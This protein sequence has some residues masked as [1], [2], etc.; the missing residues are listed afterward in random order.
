MTIVRYRIIF[1]IFSGILFVAS[2]AAIAGYG[3]HYGIDFTG[4]ALIEAG[5]LK[6]RPAIDTIRTAL[7]NAGFPEAR[8]QAAGERDVLVRIRTLDAAGHE[9][10]LSAIAGSP[11]PGTVLM[12]KRFDSIGPTIGAELR[13]KAYVAIALVLAL[14]LI[15]ISWAFR[16]VSRPISSWKYA[17]TAI[18]ALA[19]DVFLPAGMFAVLGHFYGVEADALFIT[20]LLTVLGFS[21]HDTIVVFDRIRENL[22]KTPGEKFD[23]IVGRSVTET[24]GRSV[25]TSFTVVLV[26]AAL[27][28]FGA[29][30]TRYFALTLLVG[31][32]VGTYSSIFLASPLLVTWNLW[33]EKRAA[34]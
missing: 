22:H 7:L 1:Y 11:T 9:R 14:I 29:E 32:V 4:G 26:T 12:E 28:W 23:A 31:V 18:I 6:D 8:V 33:S 16:Q 17:V 5:F 30:V 34:R 10:A 3:M 27:F 13:R 24:I 2:I 19:H 25:A 21:V 20:A 15:F